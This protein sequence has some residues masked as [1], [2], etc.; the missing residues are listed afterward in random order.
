MAAVGVF[1][2]T[3][4]LV[5]QL[6]SFLAGT[7][8]P[9][10]FEEIGKYPCLRHEPFR[11]HMINFLQF[12]AVSDGVRQSTSAQYLEHSVKV[13]EGRVTHN[14][15]VEEDQQRK[16]WRTVYTSRKQERPGRWRTIYT[17]SG[18]DSRENDASSTCSASDAGLDD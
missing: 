10:R 7:P 17:P 14:M 2:G 13:T 4:K 12:R 18:R 15:L 1:F 9:F 5:E 6:G 16:R 3:E 8:L 11:D